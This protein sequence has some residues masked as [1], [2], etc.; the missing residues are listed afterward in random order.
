[1]TTP[2]FF[3]FKSTQGLITVGDNKINLHNLKGRNIEYRQLCEDTQE[4]KIGFS[5][6]MDYL[7]QLTQL[8]DVD[9]NPLIETE[10]ASLIMSIINNHL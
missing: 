8:K 9:G 6:Y 4:F 5:E 3:S 7:R 2:D 1:M 10:T